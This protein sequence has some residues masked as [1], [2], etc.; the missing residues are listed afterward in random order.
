MKLF[1]CLFT[2]LA[3]ALAWDTTDL[4]IF[5]LVEDINANFYSMLSVKQVS[6]NLKI[7]MLMLHDKTYGS[8]FD[9]VSWQLVLI[10]RL[11]SDSFIC[12]N[13]SK[14][15]HAVKN[16]FVGCIIWRDTK[17]I[18]KTLDANAPRQE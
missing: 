1:I 13:T 11:H 17:G 18:P 7:I 10:A 12:K 3:V 14:K 9:L 4:E 5:D 16:S 6:D 2:Q 15:L 8:S